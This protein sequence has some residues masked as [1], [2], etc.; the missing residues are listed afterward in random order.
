VV[1]EESRNQPSNQSFAEFVRQ[2]D[3]YSPQEQPEKR[4]IEFVGRV[5][6]AQDDG[7]FTMSV[8]PETRGVGRVIEVRVEDVLHHEVV[9]EDS[10]G[11]KTVKVRLPEDAPVRILVQASQLLASPSAPPVAKQD[12]KPDPIKPHDVAVAAPKQD[13]IKPSDII[14]QQEWPTSSP[15]GRRRR[16]RSASASC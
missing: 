1:S 5:F 10:S 12:V 15:T 11:R 7:A 3:P 6:R 16:A 13:P 9:F 8:L 4:I 14:K 2:S